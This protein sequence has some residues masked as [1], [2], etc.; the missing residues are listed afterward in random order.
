[1]YAEQ[2]T[3]GTR[4]RV[5]VRG[6]R[7]PYAPEW[8]TTATLGLR[9]RGGADVSVE[10][11]HLGRQFGD[12]LNTRVLVAD[13]QQGVL[14]SNTLWNVAANVPVPSLGVTAF[15]AVKNL[16]DELVLVDRTRGL[17]PSMPRMVQ[18]GVERRF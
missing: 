11:V 5:D 9:H 6:N 8:T 18:V 7:L 14:P 12:A 17:L 2:N 16:F 15:G 13:G 1:V 10:A 3:A 4:T